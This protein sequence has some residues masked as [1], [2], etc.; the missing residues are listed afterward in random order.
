[1]SRLARLRVERPRQFQIDTELLA[2][3]AEVSAMH[4]EQLSDLTGG[5]LLL[6]ASG[7]LAT[8]ATGRLGWRSRRSGFR[9]DKDNG[10]CRS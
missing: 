6:S 2:S 3:Q 9:G 1:M 8:P 10:D 4:D 7:A 5:P